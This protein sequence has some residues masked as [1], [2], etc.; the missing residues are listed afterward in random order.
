MIKRVT[1]SIWWRFDPKDVGL[2]YN[3]TISTDYTL[4]NGYDTVLALGYDQGE[5][6]FFFFWSTSDENLKEGGT[7][8]N[9]KNFDLT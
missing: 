4:K 7:Q 1:E 3:P 8:K 2:G 5:K 9:I 6:E